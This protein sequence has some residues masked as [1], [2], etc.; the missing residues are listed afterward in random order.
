MQTVDLSKED[1]HAY[2]ESLGTDV[3]RERWE[4]PLPMG[5]KATRASLERLMQHAIEQSMIPAP[6]DLDEIFPGGFE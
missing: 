2:L 1:I 5:M 6:V 4:D 3:P